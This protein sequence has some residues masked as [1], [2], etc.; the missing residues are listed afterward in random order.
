MKKAELLVLEQLHD[1]V[2]GSEQKDKSS[3]E[4][5]VDVLEGLHDM[6]IDL[7]NHTHTVI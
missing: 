2:H 5:I 6:I 3:L 1:N 4:L 7:K